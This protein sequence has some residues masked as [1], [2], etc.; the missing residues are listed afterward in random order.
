MQDIFA[1]LRNS[2]SVKVAVIGFLVLVLLIPLAMIENVV[3]ERG[4]TA[5]EAR[6][7]VAGIWGGEQLVAGPVLVVP[8]EVS[9]QDKFGNIITEQ[10]NAYVLPRVLD[11]SATVTAETRY[12][13]LYKV[14]V[15]RAELRIEGVLPAL[16]PGQFNFPVAAARREEIHAVMSVSDARALTGIP[17]M[18]IGGQTAPFAPSGHRIE[19]LPAP[20]AVPLGPVFAA[21]GSDADMPFTISL[22]INGTDLL[23]FL[24]LGDTTTVSLSSSWPSPSFVGSYLPASHDVGPDGF[25][26]QWQVSNIGRAL[27]SQWIEGHVADSLLRQSAFGMQLYV[28]VDLYRLTSRA[29]RY[30]I[31]FICLTFAS[32]FLFEAVLGLRLHP[33]QYLLVGFANAL[34]F[35]LLV[36]L[37]EHVGFGPAYLVSAGASCGL[38]AGYSR[39]VLGNR[40]RAA[41]IGAIL[42]LLYAFLYMTLRAE[43]YALLTGSVGLWVALAVVMYLTRRID[44]YGVGTP[45]GRQRDLL[46][47]T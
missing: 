16:E 27:P 9:S 22:N 35:L 46:D 28:P 20:V 7:E 2:A 32:Y 23:R 42:L 4:R 12:R 31:L 33:L 34:F 30:G 5:D 8:Y 1:R 10:R 43:T 44:W 26:A 40:R 36:S 13:G 21:A 45:A 47:E 11:I 24:P 19:S 39:T 41:V 29:A 18:S 3:A 17:E 15:Y 37:A 38:I 6:T 14:P 25:R